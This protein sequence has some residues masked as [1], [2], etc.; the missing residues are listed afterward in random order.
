MKIVENL[1]RPGQEPADG[2]VVA[3][4]SGSLIVRKTFHAIDTTVEPETDY[5]TEFTP[6]ELLGAFTTDE[7]FLAAASTVP[8]IQLQMK[9]LS[10][11]RPVKIQASDDGYQN[12]INKLE[13]AG[14]LTPD[15]AASLRLGI[16]L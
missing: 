6:E 11:K 8:E 16:P 15:R 13:A 2:D 3:Y 7:A 9:V 4:Q 10:F 14:I 1:S 5:Q 12:A